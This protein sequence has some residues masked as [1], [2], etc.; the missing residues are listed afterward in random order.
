MDLEA[1]LRPRGRPR[2]KAGSEASLFG[3]EENGK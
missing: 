1:S 2:K 3:A